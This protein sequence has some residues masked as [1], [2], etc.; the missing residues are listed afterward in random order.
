MRRNNQSIVFLNSKI[1]DTQ[2]DKIKYKMKF[3]DQKFYLLILRVK[4]ND[5]FLGNPLYLGSL[6][7]KTVLEPF[8]SDSLFFLSAPD[9][10]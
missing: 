5:F 3:V 4:F 9:N 10:H 6:Y 7:N 2:N 8:H 1:L